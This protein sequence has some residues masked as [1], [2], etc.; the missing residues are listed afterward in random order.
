MTSSTPLE[1]R[2]KQQHGRKRLIRIVA[3][4]IAA[5]LLVTAGGVWWTTG[6]GKLIVMNL[7][8]PAARPAT[9][10]AADSV[11][12][13]AYQSSPKFLTMESAQDSN[14]NVNYSPASMWMALAIATQG[15]GGTT[16]S[17]MDDLLGTGSLVTEDYQSLLRSIN[18][19]Y[20]SSESEMSAANSLWVDSQYTLADAFKATAKGSFD[21]DMQSLPFNDATAKRMSRWIADHTKGALKPNITLQDREVISIIN[22]VFAD[23]R[24]KDPFEPEETTSQTFRGE[25]GEAEVSMMQHLF[26]DMVWAHDSDNDTWQRVS[27]PFDNGGSLTI[28]LP[29]VGH[30]DEIASDTEKLRW[31]MSTCLDSE[32]GCTTDAPAGWGVAAEAVMVNVSLPKFTIDSTF[33]SDETIATFRQ[34]GLTDAFTPGTADLSKMTG[35]AADLS[36]GSIIQGTR[37]E[38]NENG[39]KAAA[40]TKMGVEAAGAPVE[41]QF[42]EF[43]VDRPFLYALTTPDAIPLFIGAVRN[44]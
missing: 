44:L 36:I 12:A 37:I 3:G 20:G 10:A 28:L 9:Q 11:S 1:H 30:F 7:F 24:W 5:A 25:D 43:T 35:S 4:I 8:K 41:Q 26:D 23:G 40:F 17:Q 38:V 18:G 31:A 13:F 42:V 39:A 19:R 2:R 16:R 14:G 33:P 32:Y 22:T 21:A 34:L 29:A 27:I 15:A 6:E